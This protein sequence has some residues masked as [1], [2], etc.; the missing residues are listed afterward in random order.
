M[1]L[2]NNFEAGSFTK[3]KRFRGIGFEQ[4]YVRSSKSIYD[5]NVYSAE[6]LLRLGKDLIGRIKEKGKS[7][8]QHKMF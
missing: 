1:E 4:K 3:W 2:I 7:N 8:E 6:K 5:V